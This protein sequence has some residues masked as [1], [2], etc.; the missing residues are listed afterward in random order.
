MPILFFLSLDLIL[1][2]FY[3]K[4][5]LGFEPWEGRITGVFQDEAVAGAYLQKLFLFYYL[6]NAFISSY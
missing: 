6:Q 1:Q 5:I 4:N 2:F 3:G